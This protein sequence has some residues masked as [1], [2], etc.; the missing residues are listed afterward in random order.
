MLNIRKLVHS[1][2]NS[3]RSMG[4]LLPWMCLWDKQTIATSDM[5]LVSAFE[6]RGIDAEGKSQS[7]IDQAVGAY[8]KAFSGF[9]SGQTVWSIVDRRR[10]DFYP[11]GKISHPMAAHI[12]TVAGG[13]VALQQYQNTYS[14]ALHQRSSTGAMAFFDS[15]DRF[16]KEEDTSF[17]Q[18]MMKTARSR[19]SLR[20][21]VSLDAR[22]MEAAHN[23]LLNR[24]TDLHHNMARL[25]LRQLEGEELLAYMHSR[26]NPAS[27]RRVRLPIPRI[28]AFLNYVLANDHIDRLPTSLRFTNG[29][30]SKYVG[31]I[32]LKGWPDNST[33]PGMM[34]YLTAVD[35]EVTICHAFRFID[36]QVAAA[37]IEGV[38]KYNITASVPMFQRIIASF[39]KKPPE[40]FDQ[41]RMK[42][43]LDA[44]QAKSELIAENRAFGYHNLTLLCYGDS[45]EEMEYVREQ[46]MQRLSESDFLGHSERMHQLSAW[47]QTLPGQW[48]ASVRWSHVSFGNA[49][50]IAPI[51]TLWSGPRTCQH[52]TKAL[53]RGEQP[54]LVGFPTDSGVPF[55]WDPF[56]SG[57]GHTAFIGPTRAGKSLFVNYLLSQFKKYPGARVIRFDKDYSAYIPTILHDGQ[58]IDLTPERGSGT[59]MAPIS[60]LGDPRHV[61]FV[62]RWV[63]RLIEMGRPDQPLE[64][65]EI[66]NI[67][68]AVQGLADPE[69]AKESH[70]LKHLKATLGPLGKYLADWVDGGARAAWFDNPPVMVE[71]GDDVCFEMKRLFDDDQ[72]AELAMEYLF[73]I[74][75][76]SLDGRPVVVNV[77]ETWFFLRN[78]KFV[79]RIDDFLRTLGK[80]NG[81]LWIT[82][83][84]AAELVQTTQIQAMLDQ[85]KN[86]IFL[87]NARIMENRTGYDVL[88]LTPEQEIR[89]KLAEPKRD[90]YIQTETMTRMVNGRVPEEL[91]PLLE[92]G[93]RALAIARKHFANSETDEDWKKKYYEEVTGRP[94]QREHLEAA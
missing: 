9:G 55:Y 15:M 67:T 77:E 63:R 24:Q 93:A 27:P 66:E 53:D 10:S 41:G 38:Y 71:L 70:Q 87:P 21:K 46:C 28:P 47:T 33:H 18:A 4:D 30:M 13:A 3:A 20:A 62:I 92:A 44:E 37:A 72:V 36:R 84:G 54:A 91:V 26:A 60:L 45:E 16:V 89:I 2:Q 48:G 29:G 43:A 73:Y 69:M 34:D 85:L 19:L 51:R 14:L 61:P 7:E 8:E 64:P 65:H 80:R 94:V 88:G 22:Q 49:A 58:H 74:V 25:G 32:S 76:Q 86:R 12:Q 68:K 79:N 23:R 57:A 78:P 5:G 6:Y 42:L 82:T 90:Y 1:Y 75:E 81:A 31:V 11:Y 83:Q 35:G 39:S 56:E 40:K 59:R 52:F 50:D 17:A